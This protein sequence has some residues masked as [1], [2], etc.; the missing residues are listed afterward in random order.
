M[1]DVQPMIGWPSEWSEQRQGNRWSQEAVW[2][3]ALHWLH[4]QYRNPIR[5]A[6]F[7]CARGL[8]GN[9]YA[10]ATRVVV[11]VQ[12]RLALIAVLAIIGTVVVMVAVIAIVVMAMMMVVAVVNVILVAVRVGVNE[13]PRERADRRGIG[14]AEGRR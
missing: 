5:R 14:H 2:W 9:Q 10:G 3:S 13:K 11:H 12:L 1:A 8:D 4:R 6:K 7:V